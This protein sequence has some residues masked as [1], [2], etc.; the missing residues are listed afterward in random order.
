MHSNLLSDFKLRVNGFHHRVHF[1]PR[2]TDFICE[3]DQKTSIKFQPKLYILIRSRIMTSL[4][5][6]IAFIRKLSFLP[7]VQGFKTWCKVAISG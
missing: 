5:R 4:T 1:A 2:C 7:F 6:R 3:I